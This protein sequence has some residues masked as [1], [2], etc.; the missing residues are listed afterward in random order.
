V[1]NFQSLKLTE[2]SPLAILVRDPSCCFILQISVG[3]NI[4]QTREGLQDPR[5]PA[6]IVDL[7]LVIG[8][9]TASEARQGR[10]CNLQEACAGGPSNASGG[11]RRRSPGCVPTMV[12]AHRVTPV[13]SSRPRDYE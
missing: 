7:L 4:P 10:G 11:T 3:E 5:R 1:V 9:A 13:A 2:F 12:L 8:R 6:A